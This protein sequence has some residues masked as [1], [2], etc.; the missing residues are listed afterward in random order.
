MEFQKIS[1]DTQVLDLFH[2]GKTPI[3]VAVELNLNA[4]KTSKLYKDYLKLEEFHKLVSLYEQIN[5]NLS[6][7]L[8]LYYTI[9]KNEIKPNEIATLV[10]NSN[11]LTNLKTAILIKRN[12][13]CFIEQKIKQY[14]AQLMMTNN[15]SGYH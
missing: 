13:L 10:K 15:Y 3:E 6:S 12:E 9:V 11:E 1:H 7:F 8:K 2:Q 5:K 4:Q 14:Q